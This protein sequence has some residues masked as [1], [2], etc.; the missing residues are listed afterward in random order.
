MKE[1]VKRFLEVIGRITFYTLA[2]STFIIWLP[3]VLLCELGYESYCYI[4][5]GEDTYG[6]KISY[7]GETGSD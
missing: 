2:F 5:R 1:K 7:M 6:T 4:A 3:I